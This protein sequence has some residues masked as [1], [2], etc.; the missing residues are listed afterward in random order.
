MEKER[1]L[2]D[3]QLEVAKKLGEA[4]QRVASLN[5]RKYSCLCNSIESDCNLSAFTPAQLLSSVNFQYLS[6]FGGR[7]L[8]SVSFGE[9]WAFVVI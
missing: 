4:E 5:Y 3:T 9:N 1:Q 6:S 7:L 8:S 2:Q